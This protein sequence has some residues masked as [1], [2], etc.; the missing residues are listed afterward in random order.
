MFVFFCASRV[1][2]KWFRRD[3]EG[4]ECE[5][6]GEKLYG[7]VCEVET[8][9]LRDSTLPSVPDLGNCFCFNAKGQKREKIRAESERRKKSKVVA[10]LIVFIHI[11]IL[12]R[13]KSTS[14]VISFRHS[15]VYFADKRVECL[16]VI[17]MLLHQAFSPIS[18]VR[19][20]QVVTSEFLH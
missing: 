6:S 5:A 4:G 20:M 17:V 8:T 18:V 12:M 11:W 13:V 19:L 16:F 1:P 7:R 9:K 3:N 2:R 15:F 10:I 14:R